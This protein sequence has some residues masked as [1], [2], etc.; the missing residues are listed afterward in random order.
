MNDDK[1]NDNR[2]DDSNDT[3]SIIA[4]RRPSKKNDISEELAKTQSS[5]SDE[6]AKFFSSNNSITAP[7]SPETL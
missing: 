3:Q 6:L 5:L 7:K 1:L 2:D 4:G